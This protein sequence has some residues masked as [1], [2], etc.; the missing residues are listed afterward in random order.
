MGKEWLLTRNLDLQVKRLCC[1][2]RRNPPEAA[3]A[4]GVGAEVAG[5]EPLEPP[6]RNRSHRLK[7]RLSRP[8]LFRK[9]PLSRANRW[10][11]HH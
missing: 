7:Q 11:P 3:G 4:E 6:A 8:N 5:G 1:L 10:L 9:L 2:R